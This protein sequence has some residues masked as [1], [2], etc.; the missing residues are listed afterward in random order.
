MVRL[1]AKGFISRCA[2]L[3]LVRMLSKSA[4]KR[5]PSWCSATAAN[6]F[7]RASLS[8]PVIPHR[9]KPSKSSPTE[10]TRPSASRSM[11]SKTSRTRSGVQSKKSSSIVSRASQMSAA[12]TPGLVEG[13]TNA[14][15]PLLQLPSGA[16]KPHQK[17]ALL[18]MSSRRRCVAILRAGDCER[19]MTLLLRSRGTPR[20][21]QPLVHRSRTSCAEA[22]DSANPSVA[23]DS[24]SSACAKGRR[25]PPKGSPSS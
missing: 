25:P 9:S 23:S 3:S 18:S 22:L 4:N 14:T 1:A 2:S 5:P 21:P 24:R 16:K 20:N 12:T 17:S 6:T 7:A 15:A 13:S 8:R 11:P 19:P 10:A